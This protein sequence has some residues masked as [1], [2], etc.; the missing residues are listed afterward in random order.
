MVLNLVSNK[1]IKL[2]SFALFAS[3]LLFIVPEVGFA[4][5]ALVEQKIK[6]G[7]TSIQ[8]VLTGIVTI[9]GICVALWIVVKSLPT[10]SDP[11]AKNEMWKS[12]GNVFIAVGAAAAFVWL[13]PWFFGLW[14]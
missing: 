9:V 2:F 13:I 14:R 12:I 11:H 3:L 4:N 10:I 6:K 8:W 1:Y 5:D 7:A